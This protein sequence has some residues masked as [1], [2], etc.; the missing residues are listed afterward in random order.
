[1]VYE[2]IADAI[3]DA[4]SSNPIN[5]KLIANATENMKVGSVGD[6]NPWVINFDLNGKTLTAK[7][8]AAVVSVLSG[9]LT[10]KD[11]GNGGKVTGGKGGMFGAGGGVVVLSK[12]TFNMEGGIITGNRPN[13]SGGGVHNSCSFN[14]KGGSITSNTTGNGGGVYNSTSATFNMTG[15]SITGNSA[16]Y[17]GGVANYG[18]MT[19]GGNARISGNTLS[20]DSST[21]NLFLNTGKIVTIITGTN[22]PKSGMSIG[23]ITADVPTSDTPVQVSGTNTADYS[24]YFFSDVSSYKITNIND[25]V[26][27]RIRTAADDIADSMNNTSA[28]SGVSA[29][30]YQIRIIV[31]TTDF[32]RKAVATISNKVASIVV[33]DGDKKLVDPFNVTIADPI[34]LIEAGAN[35][36][37]IRVR[38]KFIV[39]INIAS[40][41]CG[42]NECH[43][44]L[45]NIYGVITL[46]CDGKIIFSVDL[47]DIIDTTGKLVFD[48]KTLKA[49]DINGYIIDQIIVE[50]V[51]DELLAS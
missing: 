43:I 37:E 1:M 34:A 8:N 48:G 46:A 27:L 45:D 41:M 36:A 35:T 17:N 49:Y 33:E 21:S 50:H 22:A 3:S 6:T 47:T 20:G 25:V 44:T 39:A 51:N 5:L 19:V 18:T 40:A 14:M 42:K 7:D 2:E 26:F 38:E 4:D 12:C 10:L 11:S 23:I 13:G 29:E 9:T 28:Q 15:G 24:K 16:T 30:A 31:Y 32:G